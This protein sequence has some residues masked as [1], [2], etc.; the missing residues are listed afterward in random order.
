MRWHVYDQFN[1]NNTRYM[2]VHTR[3]TPIATHFI[4][5]NNDRRCSSLG[6]DIK[7][8]EDPLVAIWNVRNAL[9][10]L[11]HIVINEVRTFIYLILAIW[12]EIYK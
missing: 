5:S 12:V 1:D 2:H 8:A 7:T 6:D 4:D 9:I 11:L 3:V 10:K